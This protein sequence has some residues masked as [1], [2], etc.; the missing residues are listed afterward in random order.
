MT[1]H[2]LKSKYTSDYIKIYIPQNDEFEKIFGDKTAYYGDYYRINIKSSDEAVK[3]I[4]ENKKFFND[5]EILK[6]DMDDVFLNITGRKF[7][8]ENDEK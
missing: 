3:I 4:D 6:G 1:P 7:K 8:E 5:F 2:N